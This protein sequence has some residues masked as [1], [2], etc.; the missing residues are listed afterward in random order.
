MIDIGERET[1]RRLADLEKRLFDLYAEEEQTMHMKAAS[2]FSRFEVRD[3]QMKQSVKDGKITEEFYKSWRVTQIG[4]GNRFNVLAEDFAHK[5]TETNKIAAQW[6]DDD[7]PHIF[8]INHNTE[9]YT[10]E[11]I[12]GAIGLNLQ[13]ENTLRRLIM[14]EPDL[15]PKREIDEELDFDWNKKQFEKEILSG[16]MQGENLKQLTDRVAPFVGENRSASVRAARTAYTNAQNGG[17]QRSYEESA[18]LGI[19]VH[20]RWIATK[21]GHTR[22]AHGFADG[23]VVRYDKPFVLDGYKLMFPGDASAPGYLVWNCRCTMRTQEKP[24][25]EAE[26]RKMRVKDPVTGKQA[27][28]DEMTY[29]E[30]LEWKKHEQDHNSGG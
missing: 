4:R 2:Y 18:K 22:E 26:K 6:L 12:N 30:W 3:R 19:D 13:D 28:V 25:I 7:I 20:K 17:R 11:Q 24:G 29:T 14:E 1:E 21:D 5:M 16:I 9:A 15:L 27:V 23:Q 8:I 10:I